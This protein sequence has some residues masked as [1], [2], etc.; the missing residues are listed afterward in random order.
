VTARAPQKDRFTSLDTLALVRELRALGR[1]RV[2]KAFDHPAQG[3]LVLT[4]RAPGEGR[5]ELR[6]VPGRYA[7]L[8]VK[9]GEHS[10]ELSPFARELR[11]L[12][13]GAVLE[14]VAE[15][16]GERYLEVTLRRGDQPE[17]LRFAVELFGTGNVVVARGE[18]IVAVLHPRTWAKRSLRIGASYLP[19]PSRGDPWE[20]GVSELAQALLSS[21]TDRVSTLAARLAFGGPVAEELL[22]R[23]KL[24]PTAPAPEEAN[25]AAESLVKA[26]RE[27]LQEVGARP[28]GHLYESEGVVLDV[29]PF[30]SQRFAGAPG[31]ESTEFATFS[32]AADRFFSELRPKEGAPSPG[33]MRL[34]ELG[35]QRAQQAEAI[36]HLEVEVAVLRGQAEAI[37]GNY[38]AAEEAISAALA[39]PDPPR[40]VEVRLGEVAVSLPTDA[41]PR[42]TGQALYEMM[43]VVQSKL[44]GAREALRGTDRALELPAPGARP[45]RSE[46]ARRRKRFWFEAYR[47]FLSS[48]GVLVIGGRD[49]ASN[50]R[51]VKRYLGAGDRYVHADIHGAPSVVVKHPAPGLP[52]MTGTTLREACQWGL[53]FSKAWRAGRASGDAFWVEAEQVSKAGASGEFVPRGAWV[54]HGTKHL[55]HDLPVELGIGTAHYESEELWCAAPPE[56]LRARGTLRAIVGPGEERERAAAETELARE[57]GLSRGE[58]QPLL[59]SG[60]L[61]IRRA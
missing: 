23:A 8:L 58:L 22:V 5:R 27:L 25:Q 11:R 39:R 54:I 42:E 33:E 41:T 53:A 61:Q 60:G 3:G 32:E 52:E 15:P 56:A 17:L 47:W 19:P 51:I 30:V 43:K 31:V 28:P 50:D 29:E 57:L 44:K 13:S 4:L 18:T 1:A 14:Q 35:R 24:S 20:F 36:E 59:P 49:A 26:I 37:L 55:L 12:L 6:L 16:R 45:K 10:E 40:R 48:D 46:P 2:D 21:R 7:A 34:S 38:T 9:A